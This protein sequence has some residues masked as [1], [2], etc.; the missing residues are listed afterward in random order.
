M[1]TYDAIYLMKPSKRL[2]YN[3]QE[4]DW[5]HLKWRPIRKGTFNI[6][7]KKYYGGHFFKVSFAEWDARNGW[8]RSWKHRL[9]FVNFFYTFQFCSWVKWDFIVH[10][11]G[12]SDLEPRRP[13]IK[14]SEG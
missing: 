10:K 6:Y 5:Y 11:D 3:D 9:V 8:G 4:T 1:N 12:P 2:I 14:E 7:L 13:I